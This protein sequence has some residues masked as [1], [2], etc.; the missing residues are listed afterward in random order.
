V[1]ITTTVRFGP[2]EVTGVVLLHRAWLPSAA[3]AATWIHASIP[4]TTEEVAAVLYGVFDARRMRANDPDVARRWV[5]EMVLNGG[6]TAI[7]EAHVDVVEARRRGTL[8]DARWN[9]CT[10][11]ARLAIN[12]SVS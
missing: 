11:L 4:V 6:C 7:E 10:R 1:D 3:P 5:A 2:Y 9:V 8:D 12:E